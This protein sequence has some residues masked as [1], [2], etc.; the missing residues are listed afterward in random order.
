MSV[1]D[2][3]STAH[4]GSILVHGVRPRPADGEGECG[5]I[6]LEIGRIQAIEPW[7]DAGGVYFVLSGDQHVKIGHTRNA[8]VRLTELQIATHTPLRLVALLPGGAAREAALHRRFARFRVHGEWFR[9]EGPLVE[10][11]VTAREGKGSAGVVMRPC[12]PRG[13]RLPSRDVLARRQA[14]AERDRVG[15]SKYDAETASLLLDLLDEGIVEPSSGPDHRDAVTRFLAAEWE[16]E[17]KAPDAQY[18]SAARWIRWLDA[19]EA[20]VREGRPAPPPPDGEAS[21]RP[22]GARS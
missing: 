7:P 21:S 14:R 15:V 5:A 2:H 4:S 6:G 11:V 22:S 9:F 16:P 3:E 12:P 1:I 13:R 18:L 10:A 19:K 8:R 17:R 20:A